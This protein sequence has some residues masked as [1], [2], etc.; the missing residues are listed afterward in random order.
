MEADELLRRAW[1]AVKEAG[2]PEP[3]QEVA[4]K[5]AF[6]FLAGGESA[7]A[8]GP[9]ARHQAAPKK[10]AKKDEEPAAPAAKATDPGAFFSALASESGEQEVDLSDI[11]QISREGNVTVTTPTKDLGA[12]M[13]EQAQTVVALVAGARAKGLGENPVSADAVRQ[14]LKRKHCYDGT[15]FSS[16]HLG[17]MKGFNAGSDKREIVLTSKWVDDF[18]AAVARAHGRKPAKNAS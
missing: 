3:L 6:D 18:S 11:L 9:A 10:R 16:Y 13:T 4:F 7:G 2:I 15:N 5:Q 17:K 8:A 14:E 12:T 1:E